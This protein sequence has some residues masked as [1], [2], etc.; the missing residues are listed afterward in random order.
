MNNQPP[1]QMS[2]PR[3]LTQTRVT[4]TGAAYPWRGGVDAAQT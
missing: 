2:D 3:D 4:R 1:R